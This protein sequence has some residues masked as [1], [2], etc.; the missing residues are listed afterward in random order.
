MTDK[1]LRIRVTNTNA[2]TTEARQRMIL[3]REYMRAGLKGRV[4]RADL[5]WW[6]GL[7]E[8]MS[9]EEKGLADEEQC[10]ERGCQNRESLM[11][12]WVWEGMLEQGK[13]DEGLSMV[14]GNVGTG[15][16]WRGIEYGER[17]CQNRES[18]RSFS[19]EHPLGGTSHKGTRCCR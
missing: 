4:S 8:W 18:W 11:Q 19:Y 7:R 15:K 12:D 14:R 10:G 17:E 16:A 2:T 5:Q 9:T 3:L 6:S 1:T 13:L